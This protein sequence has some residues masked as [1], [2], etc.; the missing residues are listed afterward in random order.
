M[1]LHCEHLDLCCHWCLLLILVAVGGCSRCQCQWHIPPSITTART[2]LI[3]VF[4]CYT[5][6]HTQ[7]SAQKA[8]TPEAT[9]PMASESELCS[10]KRNRSEGGVPGSIGFRIRNRDQWPETHT[11]HI[12]MPHMVVPY[13]RGHKPQL[14]DW[15][16]GTTPESA[17]TTEGQRQ[18]NKCR[19]V[20]AHFQAHYRNQGCIGIGEIRSTI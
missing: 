6:S 20:L 13:L 9:D 4:Y 2:R 3:H 11:P 10:N 17:A 7:F 5:R 14:N 12:F 15:T 8:K 16:S 1:W 19:P 18:K